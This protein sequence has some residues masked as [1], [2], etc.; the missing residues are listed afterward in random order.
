[1]QIFQVC[2][3][4]HYVSKLGD[5]VLLKNTHFGSDALFGTLAPF[6]N[7]CSSVTGYDA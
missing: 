4:V 6:T 3:C 7:G 1:M 5:G 2:V